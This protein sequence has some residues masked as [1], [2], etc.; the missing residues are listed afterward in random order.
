[1]KVKH[2]AQIFSQR[3]AATLRLVSQFDTQRRCEGNVEDTAELLYFF[4]RLFDS[5]NGSTKL[6][7]RGKCL[8]AGLTDE[9]DH[10]DFWNREALPLLDTMQFQKRSPRDQSR[11]PS[12]KNWSFILKNMKSIWS[13]LKSEDFSDLLTRR[14]NQDP[15]E[16]AFGQLR[17]FGA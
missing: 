13:V 14:L 16:N 1:M 4:D 15:L 10:L 8:R 9:S 5:V 12:L 2:A 17:S 3:L 6:P 11:P 7:D